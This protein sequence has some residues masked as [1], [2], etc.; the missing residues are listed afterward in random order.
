MGEETTCVFMH[1]CRRCR[2]NVA[3]Q[4][5]NSPATQVLSL[6]I[7]PKH[8]LIELFLKEIATSEVCSMQATF[9]IHLTLWHHDF[10]LR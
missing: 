3:K 4:A 7:I 1:E 10:Q 5:E 2:K 9:S 6:V 8:A